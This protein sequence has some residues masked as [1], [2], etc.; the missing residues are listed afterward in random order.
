MEQKKNYMNDINQQ[1]IKEIFIKYG[2]KKFYHAGVQIKHEGETADEVCFVKSGEL[3]AY[4][5]SPDGDDLTLFYIGPDNM[6]YSESLVPNSKIIR[7]SETMT[8]V[9]LYSM[10]GTEFLEVWENEG[11]PIKDLF[12]HFIERFALLHEYICCAHFR[13][14]KKRVAYLLY[15]NF[16]KNDG[17]VLLTHEQIAAITGINRV[18]VSRI[19]SSFSKQGI[20]KLGYRKI[21]LLDMDKL[22]K[23]FNG[24]GL[25]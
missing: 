19:V 2:Q 9:E 3:R 18:S 1:R 25:S 21:Q 16:K 20:I 12:A 5:S 4:C 23:V 24:I 22:I 14:N 17:V 15:T 6:I 11:Y 13:D 10:N 8:N 7:N